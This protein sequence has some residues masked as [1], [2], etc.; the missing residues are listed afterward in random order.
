MF[1]P[2][3]ENLKK[4]LGGMRFTLYRFQE[5]RNQSLREIKR[6]FRIL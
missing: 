6:V 3:A 4:T 5:K 1:K 2:N